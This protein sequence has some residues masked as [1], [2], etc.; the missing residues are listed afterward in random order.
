ML[1]Q[2][3]TQLK[4]LKEQRSKLDADIKR[5][6]EEMTAEMLSVLHSDKRPRKPRT[7]TPKPA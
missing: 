1:D 7:P 4:Q 6:S 3:L 2:K 5:I